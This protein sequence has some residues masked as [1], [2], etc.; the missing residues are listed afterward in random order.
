MI[1][2]REFLVRRATLHEL[3]N[4]WKRIARLHR[5]GLTM[6]Q[7]LW[8][9]FGNWKTTLAGAIAAAAQLYAAQVTTGH[10]EWPA[11]IAAFFTALLG[12]MAKDHNTSGSNI[13]G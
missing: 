7:I 10:V 5:K 4:Q 6:Q 8:A 2:F 9:I 13:A 3:N 11:L 12:V 1:R